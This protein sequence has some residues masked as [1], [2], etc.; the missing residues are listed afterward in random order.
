MTP[1]DEEIAILQKGFDAYRDEYKEQSDIWKTLEEKSQVVITVSGIF[2]AA[3]FAFSQQAH[4]PLFARCLVVLT[5]IALIC[6]LF[7]AFWVLRVQAFDMPFD[8]SAIVKQ[9]LELAAM[10]N[11]NW[12][13]DTRLSL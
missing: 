11:E 4:L 9:T 6:A 1:V 7:L 8:G 12:A 10:P 2:L 13:P 3:A 5:L